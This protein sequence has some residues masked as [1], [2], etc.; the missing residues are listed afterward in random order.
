ML[1]SAV[2]YFAM[3]LEGLI[4]VRVILSWFRVNRFNPVIQLIYTLTEPILGPIRNIIR[5]SPLGSP[6]MMLDFSPIIACFFI[7][8]CSHLLIS[9]LQGI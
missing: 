6:G 5:K 9:I 8:A 4:I 1:T 3:L 7:Q 2:G